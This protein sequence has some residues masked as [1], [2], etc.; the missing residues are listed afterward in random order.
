MLQ[1]PNLSLSSRNSGHSSEGTQEPSIKQSNIL[2]LINDKIRT[3]W[4]FN[5]DKVDYCERY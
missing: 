5:I 2:I 3:R 1:S 4:T